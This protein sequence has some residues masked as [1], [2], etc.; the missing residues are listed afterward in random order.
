MKSELSIA[1]V[2]PGLPPL[3][4]NRGWLSPLSRSTSWVRPERIG[5]TGFEPWLWNTAAKRVNRASTISSNTTSAWLSP[6]CGRAAPTLSIFATRAGRFGGR[7]PNASG[8]PVSGIRAGSASTGLRSR[9]VVVVGF[10]VVVARLVVVSC[11]VVDTSVVATVVAPSVV[12]G[13]S[14]LEPEQATAVATRPIVRT[15]SGRRRLRVMAIRVWVIT[16]STG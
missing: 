11:A 6:V 1:A 16:L 3:Q 15:R 4:R 13:D 2:T 7:W 12:G 9:S 10:A 14:A 8:T 5:P